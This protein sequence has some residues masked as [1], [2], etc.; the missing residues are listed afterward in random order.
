MIVAIIYSAITGFL[1][2]IVVTV[3][4]MG[5]WSER[6]RVSTQPGAEEQPS[7]PSLFHPI[8]QTFGNV[9]YRTEGAAILAIDHAGFADYT[10]RYLMKSSNGRYFMQTHNRYKSGSEDASIFPYTKDQA[11]RSYN[12]AADKR[13]SFEEA[14][15]EK[16]IEA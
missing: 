11:M 1:T 13:V 10:E 9:L 5:V 4:V 8:E 2:G 15:G 14:F 12:H 7:E 3:F 16:L 6:R